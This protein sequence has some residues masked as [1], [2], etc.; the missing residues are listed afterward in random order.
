M[1]YHRLGKSGLRVSELC[2]GSMTFG[3]NCS[4][5]VS[6]Q[7][8]DRFFDRGGNFIDTADIYADGELEAIKGGVLML[9]NSEVTQ[10]QVPFIREAIRLAEE[11]EQRGNLPIGVVIT[12]DDEI[13][14]RG[15]NAIWQ[16]DLALTCHAE[17][18]ALRQV[19]SQLWQRAREMTMFT[20]LEPCLMC[21]GAIL[22]HQIGQLIFGAADPYGGATISLD[23]LAPF[24]KEEFGRIQWQGP[25]FP[26]GCDP[27]YQRAREHERLR[28][29]MGGQ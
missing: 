21:A 29:M 22:L 17:M 6:H 11:A 28:E 9:T 5:A 2:L 18:E 25:A 13:I 1:Q 4:E 15:M 10:Q 3:W 7:M 8:L 12:L 19:P 14:A 26:E 27:L 16:P 23:T 20:T 24:F